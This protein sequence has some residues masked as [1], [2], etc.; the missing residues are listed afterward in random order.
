M[1]CR[2]LMHQNTPVAEVKID[3]DMIVGFS[4]V[5]IPDLLPIG[6][7]IDNPMMK[8]QEFYRIKE[9]VKSRSIPKERQ[10]IE[11]IQKVL[12]IT[13]NDAFLRSLAV[14][15]SDTYWIK[16]DG[17]PLQW[18][19][20]NYFD[21]GFDPIFANIISGGST[22]VSFSPTPDFT[23][24]GTM[25]KFWIQSGGNHF[26]YKIDT[27]YQNQESANEVVVSRISRELGILTTPYEQAFLSDKTP[28]CVCPSYIKDQYTDYINGVALKHAHIG[29]FSNF[30]LVRYI[31]RD[32]GLKKELDQIRLIDVLF[33]NTDR[34]ER[35]I[36]FSIKNNDI[37]TIQMIPAFD[38]GHCLGVVPVNKNDDM[39]LFYKKR[40][41]LVFDI[42]SEA[43]L[44]EERFLSILKEVYESFEVPEERF[45]IASEILSDGCKRLEDRSKER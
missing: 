45:C 3:A 17:C 4:R 6:T 7:R 41:D 24:D 1:D 11:R 32:L 2:T 26:L 39:K 20:V 19:D 15:L 42:E 31:E 22:A 23:T 5:F 9:W 13:P 38:N 43:D 34:H 21:N 44:D 37:H 10:G 30:S 12:Q 36:G 16:E 27:Q 29:D 40:E 18:E 14:S 25:S 33:Y 35:N 28:V 8:S